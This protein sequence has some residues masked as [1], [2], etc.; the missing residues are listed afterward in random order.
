MNRILPGD[1]SEQSRT[2]INLVQRALFCQTWSYSLVRS[3]VAV[4]SIPA[5]PHRHRA[6]AVV[7]SWPLS[8]G[9]TAADCNWVAVTASCEGDEIIR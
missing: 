9:T 4:R 8:F 7:R 2:K 1:K 6:S 5:A 3:A